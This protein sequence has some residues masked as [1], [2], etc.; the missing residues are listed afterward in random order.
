MKARQFAPKKDSKAG[1][2]TV[3]YEKIKRIF[4]M[5]FGVD[6]S[7]VSFEKRGG[8]KYCVIVRRGDNKT[9]D[10]AIQYLEGNYSLSTG[11]RIKIQREK[12]PNNAVRFLIPNTDAI[13]Y[14][15]YADTDESIAVRN[16]YIFLND[17]FTQ[18][19]SR[20]LKPEDYEFKGVTLTIKKKKEEVAF[21][22]PFFASKIFGSCINAEENQV[23]IFFDASERE[24]ALVRYSYLQLD[25]LFKSLT[26]EDKPIAW[27]DFPITYLVER[28][29]SLL[30]ASER[31]VSRVHAKDE[32]LR[33]ETGAFIKIPTTYINTQILVTHIHLLLNFEFL[34][35][36][37]NQTIYLT[38][39]AAKKLFFA[40][41][42]DPYGVNFKQFLAIQQAAVLRLTKTGLLGFHYAKNRLVVVYKPTPESKS[43]EV[44]FLAAF[45]ANTMTQKNIQSTVEMCVR[46]AKLK[47]LLDKYRKYLSSQM[48]NGAIIVT[49]AHQLSCA[50]L[51][52]MG[53]VESISASGIK[54]Y[55]INIREMQRPQEANFE[56]LRLELEGI[57]AR[58]ELKDK[59]EGQLI[60]CLK[61]NKIS[62]RFINEEAVVSLPS[63]E[64]ATL[65]R[66]VLTAIEAREGED[67]CKFTTAIANVKSFIEMNHQSVF[68]VVKARQQMV[69]LFNV[70][71]K[72]YGEDFVCKVKQA[73]KCEGEILFDEAFFQ[74]GVDRLQAIRKLIEEERAKKK[75]AEDAEI[76]VVSR[77]EVSKDKSN[78]EVARPRSVAKK[79]KNN[80]VINPVTANAGSTGKVV[81][82]LKG[83]AS[84]K[85]PAIKNTAPKKAEKND[86]ASVYSRQ[87]NLQ[88]PQA[89]GA[90]VRASASYYDYDPSKHVVFL[91]ALPQEDSK[92]T[93]E[94]MPAQSRFF[95]RTAKEKITASIKKAIDETIRLA[96]EF[97]NDFDEICKLVNVEREGYQVLMQ[98]E[99][100]Q[101]CFSLC[102]VT[103]YLQS[104]V[105]AHQTIRQS[106]MERE[107]DQ[108]TLAFLQ[109]CTDKAE[110]ETLKGLHDL[111]LLAINH[112]S[113]RVTLNK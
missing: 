49:A 81:K 56:L 19:L 91:D 62:V 25:T 109:A 40:V 46:F 5:D 36:E 107:F 112:M 23:V 13:K 44:E 89:R 29:N 51:L 34:E 16:H 75:R 22:Q 59:F 9:C 82:S 33:E 88:Q 78:E 48:L 53:A 12:L 7:D 77:L 113:E 45:V 17:C 90:V 37:D 28:F 68:D 92:E 72:L 73:L 60:G 50:S 63:V 43:N 93:S 101:M 15:I 108:A 96:K 38:P 54:S 57:A 58:E 26:T 39:T 64:A 71:R 11:E 2:V 10:G 97:V 14:H 110:N 67:G 35:D 100:H 95:D 87:Q 103:D 83:A 79:N 76:E 80:S 74:L 42:L 70:V 41:S 4:S 85:H 104:L 3:D 8:E 18:L 6:E 106:Q 24:N 30:A 69:M 55:K 20:H 98:T 86:E 111:C 105:A 94:E 102:I 32:G 1:Q 65:L 61:N 27:S 99:K 47:I 52:V 21:L 84:T 66:P 31:C